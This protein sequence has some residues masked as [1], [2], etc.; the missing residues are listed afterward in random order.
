MWGGLLDDEHPFMMNS[1]KIT[2]MT[3]NRCGYFQI[4]GNIEIP[5]IYQGD[6]K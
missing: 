5:K 3:I 6:Y 1:G 4:E 2:C